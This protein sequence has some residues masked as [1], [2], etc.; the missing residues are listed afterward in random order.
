MMTLLSVRQRSL[1]RAASLTDVCLQSSSPPRYIQRAGLVYLI[2]M[3]PQLSYILLYLSTSSSVAPPH[4]NMNTT[5]SE[6]SSTSNTLLDDPS[7]GV[8]NVTVN[9]RS[10]S[11]VSNN[12]S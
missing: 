6:S 1:I 7:V 9:S 10:S 3:Q 8:G 11:I 4:P 2:L 12:L 5:G